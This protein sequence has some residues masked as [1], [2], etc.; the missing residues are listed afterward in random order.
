MKRALLL[1]S[2]L[3]IL[4]GP[5]TLAQAQ[6]AEAGKALFKSICSLCHEN[7]KNKNRVGPSLYGVVDRHTGVVPGYAYSEANTNSG[8]TWTEDALF[9]Y[10]EN[11]QGMVPGTKMT[12]AGLKDPKKR[13]DLIAYLKTLHD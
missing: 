10:L 12:Y 7:I 5:I 6:D 2:F 4:P 9:I 8:I 3:V 13:S 1:A 11:P